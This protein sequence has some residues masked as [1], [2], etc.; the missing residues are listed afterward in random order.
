MPRSRQ[1]VLLNFQ[2]KNE[3][4]RA[5]LNKTKEYLNDGHF[6]IRSIEGVQEGVLL[7]YGINSVQKYEI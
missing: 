7:L 4:S 2:L 5:N 3:T 1:N 6:G